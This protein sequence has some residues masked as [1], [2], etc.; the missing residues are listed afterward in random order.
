MKIRYRVGHKSLACRALGLRRQLAATRQKTGNS[1]RGAWRVLSRDQ[2]TNTGPARNGKGRDL[3]L[4]IVAWS[5]GR[6]IS[7]CG[8]AK[9]TTGSQR[10]DTYTD[11]TTCVGTHLL[12]R[13][14]WRGERTPGGVAL[15][16]SKYPGTICRNFTAY[17][18]SQAG[19]CWASLWIEVSTLLECI[20]VGRSLSPR[21]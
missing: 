9:T 3:R 21:C 12:I 11:L 15:H 18:Q 1:G 10:R 6:M 13:K 5:W 4:R 7:L 17:R 8:D 14:G 20:A 19:S 2:I 16:L